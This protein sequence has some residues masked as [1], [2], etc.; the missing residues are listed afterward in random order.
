MTWGG[1]DFFFTFP[2]AV[3]SS[4]PFEFGVELEEVTS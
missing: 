2:A 4:G 3:L 1:R